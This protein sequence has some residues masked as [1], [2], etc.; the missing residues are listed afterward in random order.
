MPQI[1]FGALSSLSKLELRRLAAYLRRKQRSAL[2]AMCHKFRVR[3]VPYAGLNVVFGLSDGCIRDYLEIMGEI[4]DVY[5]A[6][7]NKLRSFYRRRSPLGIDLQRQA[8][9]RA[10]NSKFAGIKNSGDTYFA[11][12]SKLV[13]S[14]GALTALLHRD[15]RTTERGVFVV[16]L[17]NLRKSGV[18][19]TQDTRSLVVEVLS[20]GEADGLLRGE[21]VN[22]GPDDGSIQ[23]IRFRLHRRFAPKY[24]FSFRGP[25]EPAFLPPDMV[26]EICSAPTVTDPKLWAAM[27]VDKMT[28][29]DPMQEELTF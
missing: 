19:P 15:V 25:Y 14:L 22:V 26:A 13:D 2:I 3:S 23:Q 5:S 11:E 8:V 20:R 16:D 18:S 29:S 27:A 7:T 4:Y 28:I 6:P 10:A 17:A 9:V 24:G 12:L 1:P 21:A